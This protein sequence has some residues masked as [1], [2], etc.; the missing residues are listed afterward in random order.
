[1]TVMTNRPRLR[2]SYAVSDQKAFVP[3]WLSVDRPRISTRIAIA[4]MRFL[5]DALTRTTAAIIWLTT[6]Q[7]KRT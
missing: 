6:R 4:V 2:V 3:A 7:G 1:M 5:T